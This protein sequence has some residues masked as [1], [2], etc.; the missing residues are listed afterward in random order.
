[1]T[2]IDADFLA[3]LGLQNLP[4]DKK[5]QMMQ[6]LQTELEERIGEKLTAGMSEE[7][8]TEFDGLMEGDETAMQQ[9]L[10]TH[11]P[12]YEHS[13]DFEAFLKEAGIPADQPVPANVLS[14]YSV[15]SWVEVNHPN[16][17]EAVNETIEEMKE[18]INHN[19]D[20][21]LDKA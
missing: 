1:M 9:W 16:Y 18:E 14:G 8:L 19:R 10:Q 13:E 7:Q 17:Q 6:Q 4:D 12:G 5:Q 11:K 2:Q 20:V 21:I 15:A 3:S